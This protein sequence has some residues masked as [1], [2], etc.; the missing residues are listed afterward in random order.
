LESNGRLGEPQP[1]SVGDWFE[2]RDD[3][4]VPWCGPGTTRV[5]LLDRR[6]DGALYQ[7]EERDGRGRVAVWIV[8]ESRIVDTFEGARDGSLVATEDPQVAID[9]R[10]HVADAWAVSR[11]LASHDDD[12]E[13]EYDADPLE[14]AGWTL[15]AL[16]LHASK[17]IGPATATVDVWVSPDVPGRMLRVRGRGTLLLVPI[18]SLTSELVDF[19]HDAP[20]TPKGALPVGAWPPS[21]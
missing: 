20:S 3:D 14:I 13:V 16:R 12:T 1:W 19:G 4:R 7:A 10:A 17:S 11:S 6:G 9:C 18:V 15:D 8:R 5:S 21:T 2:W